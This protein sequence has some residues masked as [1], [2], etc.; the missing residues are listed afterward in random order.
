MVVARRVK[1]A[2]Q[3]WIATALVLREDPEREALAASEIVDR[4]RQ[5]FGQVSPAVHAHVYQHCVASKRPNP[6]R[7]RM[8]VQTLQRKYRLFRPGD[9]YHPDREG[10]RTAPDVKETPEKYLALL[11]WYRTEYAPEAKGF[12]PEALL[13]RLEAGASGRRDV[14][15]EHDRYLADAHQEGHSGAVV[16]HS[17]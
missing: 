9:S 14:S 2:D 8:L 12:G 1:V 3:V 17:S 7:L 10:G 16:S 15:I 5:E 6:A 4:V 13:V 11:E